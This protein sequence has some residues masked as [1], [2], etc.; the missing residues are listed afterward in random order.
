MALR[1][2]TRRQLAFWG[3]PLAAG[4]VLV[5]CFDASTYQGGS[6]RDIGGKLLQAD[7]GEEEDD[8]GTGAPED[9]G[10]TSSDAGTRDAGDGG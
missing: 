3:A 6:R 9:A 4:L 5:A 7:G 8:G 2:V 1:Q 10:A